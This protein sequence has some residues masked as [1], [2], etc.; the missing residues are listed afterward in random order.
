VKIFVPDPPTASDPLIVAAVIVPVLPLT[1][2]R[3]EVL[4]FFDIPSLTG[5]LIALVDWTRNCPIDALIVIKSPLSVKSSTIG[6][7]VLMSTDT[8]ALTI[9]HPTHGDTSDMAALAITRISMSASA[10]CLQ[11]AV[12][13]APVVGQGLIS[14]RL[15]LR[16]STDTKYL[17]V[18]SGCMNNLINPSD[19]GFAVTGLSSDP[20]NFEKTLDT[21]PPAPDVL[22][23]ECTE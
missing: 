23:N 18:D 21:I 8:S 22:T 14:W 9:R 5:W 11:A 7:S 13:I 4:N 16:L 12:V 20:N 15:T 10:L 6:S 2:L 1:A 19:V 3:E 17:N